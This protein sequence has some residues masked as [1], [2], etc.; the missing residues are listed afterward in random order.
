[1]AFFTRLFFHAA[2]I[3]TWVG[4]AEILTTEIRNTGHAAANAW[5][6]LGGFLSPYLVKESTNKM[7]VGGTMLG[8]ALL[9]ALCA[10]GLPETKDHALGVHPDEEK[11][12]RELQLQ[13]QVPD[14]D[15]N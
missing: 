3:T 8:V 2:N 11:K 14:K 7:V 1:L 4:T 5:A 10:W 9:A 13:S 15:I 6:R 12:K